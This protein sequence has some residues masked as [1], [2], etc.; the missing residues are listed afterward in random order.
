MYFALYLDESGKT[1]KGDFTSLCGYVATMD[2]W[3][4]FSLDWDNLRF[5]WQVPPIHMARIMYPDKKDDLWKRKYESTPR[6]MW[7]S[8]RDTMLGEF[9]QLVL[10][11][12]SV[13]VGSVVDAEAYRRIRETPNMRL[14][15]E[16]SNVYTLQNA[17]MNAL[18]KI[19]TVDRNPSVSIIIDDDHETAKNYY[20]SLLNL[21]TMIDNPLLP[22]EQ[23]PRFERIKR[24]VHS[25]A[26]CNDAFF[27]P[28]QAADMISY[29]AR[30]FK[31]EQKIGVDVE[32]SDR[33]ALLTRGGLAQPQ[34]YT[35]AVLE[36]IARDVALKAK[37]AESPDDGTPEL[38][39]SDEEDT[40]RVE[41]GIAEAAGSGETGQS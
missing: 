24:C 19:E 26:F 36:K 14:V 18:D 29:E 20:D 9:G 31:V 27:P 39:S 4:R 17:I 22:L 13:C 12:N 15:N 3:A 30:R 10:N 37:E 21:R 38:R 32:P 16:D 5:K 35:E 33:Y 40:Q 7:D 34:F 1:H 8:W 2:E 6:D 23:R 25:L 11:A 41:S 28:L